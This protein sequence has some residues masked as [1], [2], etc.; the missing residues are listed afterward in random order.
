MEMQICTANED[1]NGD[2]DLYFMYMFCKLR[3]SIYF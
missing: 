3:Y 1:T 2:A